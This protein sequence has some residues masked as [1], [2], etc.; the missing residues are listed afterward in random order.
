MVM[1]YRRMGLP[2]ARTV[3][4]P[5]RRMPVRRMGITDRHGL[6]V[7]SSSAP[8][9]GITQATMGM[10]T[11]I[12]A[13]TRMDMVATGMPTMATPV[14]TRTLG[15]ATDMSAAGTRTADTEA[16]AVAAVTVAGADTG[17]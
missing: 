5:M 13:A 4:T 7:G 15:E 14:G 8:V 9:P 12:T 11:D 16:T 6:A 2:H 3:T 1:R 10:D 17:K